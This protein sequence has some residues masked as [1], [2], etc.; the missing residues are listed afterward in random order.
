MEYV[1]VLHGLGKGEGLSGS[2]LDVVT[3]TFHTEFDQQYWVSAG[4]PF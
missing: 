1:C 4:A 2:L 3:C